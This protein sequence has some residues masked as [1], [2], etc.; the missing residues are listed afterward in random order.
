MEP[1][2]IISFSPDEQEA[3]AALV[4]QIIPASTEFN[5]PSANDPAILRD[6]LISGSNLQNT[7]ALALATFANG[8][9]DAAKFRQTFPSEA[10][11]IQTL[12][13]QCYYRDARV[14][15]AL[16]IEVRAP[17]PLGYTQE[18]NDFSILDPVRNRGEIYR[19][20]P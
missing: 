17:F 7:L 14:M 13:A 3:L 20:T 8:T 18:P 10:A 9:G 15:A 1:T 12:T 5:Q 4:G 19:K 11:L 6:I 2:E 16:N